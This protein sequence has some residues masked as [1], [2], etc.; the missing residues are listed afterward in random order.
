M[1]QS[2]MLESKVTAEKKD[3]KELQDQMVLMASQVQR[4]IKDH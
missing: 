2:E 3:Q 4:E 1:V